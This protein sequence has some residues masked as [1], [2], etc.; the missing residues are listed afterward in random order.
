[1]KAVH[2]FILRCLAVAAMTGAA[3]LAA[4]AQ[5]WSGLAPNGENTA[6]VVRG[7]TREIARDRAV[8]AC[9]RVSNSCTDQPAL[10]QNLEDIFALVCCDKPRRG[11][12]AAPR[13][14]R[15]D[16]VREA[17]RVLENANF[18]SC[19]T[20]AFYSARTGENLPLNEVPQ[21]PQQ[22]QQQQQNRDTRDF[23]NRDTN[24]NQPPGTDGQIVPPQ[25]D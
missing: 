2:T 14:N 5:G 20:V 4:Q 1:M 11:C 24:R 12:V 19:Q 13:Q 7:D 23:Q 8:A 21:R 6:P 25:Q 18:S 3:T 22:Q 9:R 16:G 17:L 10:T 15:A